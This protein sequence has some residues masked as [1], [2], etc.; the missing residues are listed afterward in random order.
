MGTEAGA[1]VPEVDDQYWLK[2]SK[3]PADSALEKRDEAAAKAQ[4]L[5]VWLWGIYTAYAAVG[6]VLSGKQLSIL[7]VVLIA[8]A[9]AFLIAV[10]W[11][12]VW[13]Q[14]PIP[15]RFDPRSP[16]EIREAYANAVDSRWT[17]LPQGTGLCRCV[18]S[19]GCQLSASDPRPTPVRS[20][21]RQA[22]KSWGLA[23]A[24]RSV[25][26]RIRWG[27]RSWKRYSD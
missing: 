10:Y 7:S 13:V 5:A 25:R 26:R 23:A 27:R 6:F 22:S 1:T 11:A 21:Y 15:T 16:S 3:A 18:G 17:V 19:G 4:N 24:A 9:S 20:T 2:Y 12:T 8:S 14:M